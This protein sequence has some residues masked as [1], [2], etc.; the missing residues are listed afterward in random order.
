[1]CQCTALHIGILGLQTQRSVSSKTAER[2]G[3]IP[4]VHLVGK[5]RIN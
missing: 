2:A 3:Y 1:M 4:L 5:D